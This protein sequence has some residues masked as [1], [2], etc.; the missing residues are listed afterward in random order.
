MKTEVFDP[1]GALTIRLR[2]PRAYGLRLWVTFLLLRMT[3]WVSP[4]GIEVDV[5]ADVE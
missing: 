5:E 3:A 2:M 4:H 1:S